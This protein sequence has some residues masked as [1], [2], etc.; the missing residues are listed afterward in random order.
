MRLLN[1][2]TLRLKYFDKDDQ[3]KP[4]YAALS[5]TWGK[6][7]L[8]FHEMMQRRPK[9]PVEQLAGFK[10]AQG[11][12][13]RAR[14]DGY[15][16]IWIDTCCI[17]KN[18]SSELCQA[19]NSMW[20]WYYHSA[21]C[22]AYLEDVHTEFS[23]DG[24]L[25]FDINEFGKSKWFTRG[26]TLQELIAPLSV[27]FLASDWTEL[28]TKTELRYDLSS[29]TG[30]EQAVFRYP[31]ICHYSIAQKM[32]WPSRRKTSV[33]EDIAY[34]LL[35]LFDVNIPLLYGEG[36][37]KAFKRL[38]EA[39]I[40]E[41]NDESIFAWCPRERNESSLK[42]ILA[43]HPSDFADSKEILSFS[44]FKQCGTLHRYDLTNAGLRISLPLFKR[45][46]FYY[47]LL[48][49]VDNCH[50]KKLVVLPLRQLSGSNEYERAGFMETVD[51][52]SP[53]TE[54]I[55]DTIYIRD[56]RRS[57][58]PVQYQE[59]PFAAHLWDLSRWRVF[60][61][62][63]ATST[64]ALAK[65][66]NWTSLK[67]GVN[68]APHSNQLRVLIDPNSS[69]YYLVGQRFPSD[70]YPFDKRF[71]FDQRPFNQRPFDKRFPF[72]QRPFDKRFPFDKHPFGH[73]PI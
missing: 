2:R 61:S 63:N 53:S 25:G 9:D 34:C 52:P 11:A 59:P 49:C 31:S 38:Q 47:A 20:S 19:I 57:Q 58:M 56:R 42:S 18:S 43:D 12:C 69:A 33:P 68:L 24:H 44:S 23:N 8:S 64:E 55:H 60:G 54:W 73:R 17:N 5:H 70:Q 7:E 71:P 22:Y 51:M 36:R 29:I 41:S 1:T 50:R 46:L 40:K 48:R 4:K 10:K 62:A 15:E 45:Q 6:E 26:W 39:L 66:G 27:L 21:R 72:D 65:A 13:R 16:W 14:R 3:P 28:G 35:G 37:E 30:I 67:K 32:S